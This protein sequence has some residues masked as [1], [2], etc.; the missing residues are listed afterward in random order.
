[1]KTDPNL[2]N[3]DQKNSVS[4]KGEVHA[5]ILELQGIQTLISQLKPKE[6][7][8]AEKAEDK[9]VETSKP[10]VNAAITDSSIHIVNYLFKFILSREDKF[11]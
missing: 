6:F 7:I 5:L 1:M 4:K 10:S 9:P 8:V 11:V 2:L 3:E